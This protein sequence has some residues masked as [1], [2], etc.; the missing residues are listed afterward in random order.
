LQT[1]DYGKS[2]VCFSG[3]LNA[4]R[5]WIESHT[6]VINQETALTEDYYQCGACKAENTWA[7]R[8]KS[9]P[10]LFMEDNHD[11]TPVFG[12]EVSVVFRR[13]AYLNQ[14]YKEVISEFKVFGKPVRR[15]RFA[16][17][18][19][20]LNTSA[21]ICRAGREGYPL[22]GRTEIGDET[23]GWKAII[24]YPIKTININSDRNLFQVDTGP[25]AWPDLAS[26]DGKSADTISLAFIAY[27]SFSSADFIIEAPTQIKQEGREVCQVHHY[28]RILRSAAKNSIYAVD[29]TD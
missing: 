1:I 17:E 9:S 22:V 2:F 4:A 8:G 25:I 13:K 11:Y 12:S 5:F 20:L 23:G 19:R 3:P 15:I 27:D 21:E 16:D 14:R 28:S 7:S 26:R 10:F 29:G 18:Q 24:E 6:R